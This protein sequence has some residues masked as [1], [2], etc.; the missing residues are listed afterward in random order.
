M[1]SLTKEQLDSY[2]KNGY[3]IIN[4]FAND[5][6]IQSLKQDAN[7]LIDEFDMEQIR[8]FTTENQ[9]DHMDEYFLNSAGTVRCFFEEEAFDKNGNLTVDKHLAIN[10]IGHA[11]H[12]LETIFQRFSYRRDLLGIMKD[13][14]LNRP[15]IAQSQY[16]FKQPN[17]GAKVNPHTDST[18]LYTKPLSCTGA[19][20][21][22][23]DATMENG[24]LCAIPGSHTD[25][26][27][28]EQFVLNEQNTGTEFVNTSSKRVQWPEEALIPLK[29]KKGA[30]V[31]IHGGVVHA[32]Y[33]N[34]SSNSRHAYIVHIV[35]QDSEWSDRNW[36]QRPAEM[37]FEDM[38]TVVN[39]L[40]N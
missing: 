4:D 29:V 12:D 40:N 39:R 28:Q 25:Y 37:P 35:D 24:C 18:F 22:L 17:I 16:I 21:A 8:I 3:L 1:N 23:E 11:M 27:I 36:L 15:A 7:R 32:S 9:T 20:I 5:Q 2:Q 31:L 19:W 33:A 10:K 30:L 13:I 26:P 38:E 34:R 14:G 6:D